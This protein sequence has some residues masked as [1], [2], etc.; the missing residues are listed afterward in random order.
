MCAGVEPRW[1]RGSAELMSTAADYSG[2][3]LVPFRDVATVA[4]LLILGLSACTAEQV[5]VQRPSPDPARTSGPTTA[6]PS[7]GSPSPT[8]ATKAQPT[9]AQPTRAEPT[10][11]EQTK[12][13]QTKAVPKPEQTQ[14]EPTPEPVMLRATLRIPAIGLRATPV[15]P[16]RGSP[17]DGPGTSI[18]NGGVAASPFGARAGVGPGQIGNYIVTAHRTSAGAPFADL[19]SLG[20]GEHAIVT[21]GAKVLDY[22]IIETRSTSFRSQ[23]SLARQAAAVPGHPGQQADR[24]MITLSTCATPEDHARGNYWAD[25][26]DNPEHRI[27]KIGVLVGIRRA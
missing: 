25:E 3:V 10:R 18:Q 2:Q 27:D 5:V 1:G 16:Y 7:A 26:F 23:R 15:V 14:A 8:T 11:A 12:A 22:R 20:R 4:T 19:P 6:A 21:A 24:P 9:R 17:D 13:E